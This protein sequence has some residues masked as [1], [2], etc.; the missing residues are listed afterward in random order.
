M[1]VATDGQTIRW[2]FNKGDWDGPWG[3]VALTNTTLDQLVRRVFAN[4][5]SMTWAEMYSATGGRRQGNNHHPVRVADLSSK[6]K[7]R[8]KE[9]RLADLDDLV[10]LRVNST[11]RVYG[12]REGRVFQFPWY[13]PWHDAPARAVYPSARR[14]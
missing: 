7:A 11:T 13:D 12:I 10:S 9:I 8:L 4:W 3:S 5:D 2:Q 14:R 1:P 6:A